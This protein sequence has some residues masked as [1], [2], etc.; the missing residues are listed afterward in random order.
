MS[1]S[2]ASYAI[3]LRLNKR[4]DSS[5][6]S[7]NRAASTSM[8]QN[9]STMLCFSAMM[10]AGG[11]NE[12][13]PVEVPLDWDLLILQLLPIAARKRGSRWTL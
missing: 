3:C 6:R 1:E 4:L 7:R 12:R 8:T 11:A 5:I 10:T 9:K 2:S 13:V